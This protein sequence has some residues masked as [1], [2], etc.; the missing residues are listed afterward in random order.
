[1]TCPLAFIRSP[2]RGGGGLLQH[3]APTGA[4]TPGAFENGHCSPWK[5]RSAFYWT[6]IFMS[7][8][9]SSETDNVS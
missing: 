7:M 6:H 3:T 5:R 8:P 1:M 2:Q 9:V 4:F